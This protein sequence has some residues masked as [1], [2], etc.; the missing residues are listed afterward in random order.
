MNR[1]SS[2]IVSLLASATLF[3]CGG[4]DTTTSQDDNL[5]GGVES[6]GAKLR[7]VGTI[8]IVDATTGAYSFICTATLIAPTLVLTAKHCTIDIAGTDLP[9]AGEKFVDVFHMAFAIGN[10]NQP[11]E[12]VEA[13][14]ADYALPY[15]TGFMGLGNDVG[16]YHL[17]RPITDVTPIA[18]AD[19]SIAAT[20]LNKKYNAI[21]YGTQNDLQDWGYAGLNGTRKVGTET[22]NALDGKFYSLAFGTF[23]NFNNWLIALYGSAVIAANGPVVQQMWDTSDLAAGYEIYLGN[24]AGDSQ[25]CHGDSGG[26]LLRSVTGSN[27]KKTLEIF[28]VLSGGLGSADKACAFGNIYSAIAPS[29]RTF[30]ASAKTYTDPCAGGYTPAGSCEGDIAKRCT[31]KWEGDRSLAVVDCSDLGQTCMLDANKHA[32]C[33]DVGSDP[34]GAGTTQPPPA[35]QT[36]PSLTQVRA[37]VIK[38][39]SHHNDALTMKLDSAK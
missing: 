13:I 9:M 35:T 6:G 39:F 21:G 22:L 23:E 37:G 17:V 27:G 30:L 1:T 16:V 36:A 26:P 15:D 18:V 12:M 19:V 5:I 33:F 28:G 29:T 3:A 4:P 7:A 24:R 20:D 10:A 2:A 11:T 31:D 8:G 14:A 38:Q 34:S 32:G 25:D